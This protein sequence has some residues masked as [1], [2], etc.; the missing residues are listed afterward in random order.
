[1]LGEITEEEYV[2]ISSAPAWASSGSTHNLKEI[3]NCADGL[4]VTM[5]GLNGEVL[6][7]PRAVP[8]NTVVGNLR[9]LVSQDLSWPPDALTLVHSSKEVGL[10]D[11]LDARVFGRDVLFYLI[12]SAPKE[13]DVDGVRYCPGLYKVTHAV[14]VGSGLSTFS[15]DLQELPFG[16]L[17]RV[18]AV[19]L[20]EEENRVRGYVCEYTTKDD[21]LR[22]HPVR[23]RSGWISLADTQDGTWVQSVDEDD[24][25]LERPFPL[26]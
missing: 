6:W 10:S 18:S 24:A 16:T 23:D 13:P 26:G 3:Q 17:V 14:T 4:I 25:P 1:M 21:R 7:G 11:E 15:Q 20:V 2:P 19:I 22:S 5:V 8:E 9:R 12:K